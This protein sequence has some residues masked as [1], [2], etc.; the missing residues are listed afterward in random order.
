[1]LTRGCK[2]QGG[3]PPY[4]G[5]KNLPLQ[6]IPP[7]QSGRRKKSGQ[8]SNEKGRGYSKQNPGNDLSPEK[9]KTS[10]RKLTSYEKFLLNRKKGGNTF[11]VC[12]K[13]EENVVREGGKDFPKR[14]GSFTRFRKGSRIKKT[15]EKR[16]ENPIEER[17]C[18]RSPKGKRI[19][20][21]SPY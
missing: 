3:E 13:E 15:G 8:K 21:T 1:M 10:K 12:P 6:G 11:M 17:T 2:E 20:S 7:L 4:K 9:R 19:S 5:E 18:P 14:E 16:E